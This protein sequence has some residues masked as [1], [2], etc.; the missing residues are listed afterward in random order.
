MEK[1]RFSNEVFE[2]GAGRIFELLIRISMPAMI[3]GVAIIAVINAGLLTQTAGLPDAVKLLFMLV[4]VIY[5]VPCLF[6]FPTAW[7]LR[8]WKTRDLKD[9]YV[10]AGKKSIEYHKI[11]DKTSAMTRENVYV[12]T[13]IKKVEETDRKYTVIGNIVEQGSGVRSSEL[14]IPKAYENMELIKRAAR[15][16]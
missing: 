14:V 13:Q 15:Y 10:M 4:I 2:K 16:R 11:V 12:A 8:S 5:V 3:V 1:L 7:M 6:I 9:T